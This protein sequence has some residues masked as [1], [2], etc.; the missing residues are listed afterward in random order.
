MRAFHLLN[1][2]IQIIVL[3]INN[4]FI[5]KELHLRYNKKLK[6]FKEKSKRAFV[7]LKSITSIELDKIF[8]EKSNS[9]KLWNIIN[10]IYNGTL[11]DI[12][13]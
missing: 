8:K 7:I 12:I 3:I 5:F 1:Y 2:R 13:D 4:I 10:K 9:K 11:L 6:E